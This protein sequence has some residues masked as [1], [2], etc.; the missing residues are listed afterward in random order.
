MIQRLET[1]RNDLADIFRNIIEAG[2]S[3]EVAL[4]FPLPE[5]RQ[6]ASR[7]PVAR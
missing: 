2:G 1:A 3:P 7:R 6:R 5:H 4:K